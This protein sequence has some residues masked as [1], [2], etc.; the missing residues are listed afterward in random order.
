MYWS[1]DNTHSRNSIHTIITITKHTPGRADVQ[2]LQ[3]DEH[4]NKHW[5]AWS[6]RCGG[7]ASKHTR[8]LRSNLHT[9]LL[10]FK[11]L[12]VVNKEHS[13]VHILLLLHVRAS[14]QMKLYNSEKSVWLLNYFVGTDQRPQKNSYIIRQIS[15]IC[16]QHSASLISHKG[17]TEQFSLPLSARLHH[18]QYQ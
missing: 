14:I 2:E 7:G 16:N 9:Y 11:I 3:E 8:F 17:N 4:T 1:L 13:S 10:T 5:K 12:Y 6:C 15:H 18:N